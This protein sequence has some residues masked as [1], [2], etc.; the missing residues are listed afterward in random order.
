[1][2]TP[3]KDIAKISIFPETDKSAHLFLQKP[4]KNTRVHTIRYVM[5]HLNKVQRNP[6]IHIIH[7]HGDTK[8]DCPTNLLDS[9]NESDFS[10]DL[11]YSK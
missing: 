3:Q 7:I 11:T 5:L 6:T 9:L 1:M 4:S 8:R 10:E 2:N